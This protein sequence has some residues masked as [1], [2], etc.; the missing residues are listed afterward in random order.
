VDAFLGNTQ[1][2]AMMAQHKELA[3]TVEGLVSTLDAA[4]VQVRSQQKQRAETLVS[5]TVRAALACAG[6]SMR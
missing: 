3:A 4:L 6:W 2:A 1:L 5:C